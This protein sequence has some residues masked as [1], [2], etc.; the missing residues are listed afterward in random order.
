MDWCGSGGGGGGMV[1]VDGKFSSFPL[2]MERWGMGGGIISGST[3]SGLTVGS[4]AK[5]SGTGGGREA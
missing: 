3:S 1:E 4:W 5:L 2:V